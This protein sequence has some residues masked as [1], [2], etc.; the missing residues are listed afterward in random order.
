MFVSTENGYFYRNLPNY[1]I[2]TIGIPGFG[3]L[4]LVSLFSGDVDVAM[5]L[6]SVGG[7]LFSFLIRKLEHEGVIINLNDKILSYPQMRLSY[8]KKPFPRKEIAIDEIQ[9]VSGYTKVEITENN[10]I[11]RTHN[12][13]LY[14]KFGYK[15]FLFYTLEERN[16][17]YSLLSSVGHF[18]TIG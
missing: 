9:S 18:D 14:G 17:F 15:K 7:F 10:N 1:L 5:L 3:I 6:L 16:Q 2:S 8:F 13:T 12:L 11:R 4:G